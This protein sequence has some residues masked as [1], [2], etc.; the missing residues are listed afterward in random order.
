MFH[1]SRYYI[2]HESEIHFSLKLYATIIRSFRFEK[3]FFFLLSCAGAKLILLARL[4]AVELM[5]IYYTPSILMWS[6][7]YR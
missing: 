4:P 2:A 1:N 7:N 6:V 3:S 5:I